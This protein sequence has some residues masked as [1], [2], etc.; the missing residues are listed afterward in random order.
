MDYTIR[1]DSGQVV[2]TSL[3]QE[4]LSY[5]QG[6]RQIVPGVERALEGLDEG[7]VV[8][9]VLAPEDAYGPRNPAGIFVVAR[10][11]FPEDE[12]PGPGMTFSARRRDGTSFT[13]RV[14]DVD[15]QMVLVDTNHPLAGET[16]HV[17]VKV[18]RVRA[19]TTEEIL[20]GKIRAGASEPVYLA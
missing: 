16:L 7:A 2:E 5:L 18:H 19:A 10:S 12:Q 14:L 1:L 8:N 15:E 17:T 11:G 6:R 9:V 13:F 3:G 20:T 4:P